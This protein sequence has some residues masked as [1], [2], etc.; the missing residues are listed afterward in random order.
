MREQGFSPQEVWR[1]GQADGLNWV[2]LVS[3]IRIVCGLTL[4]QAKEVMLRA[5]GVAESL[6]EYQERVIL[7]ALEQLARELE[8]EA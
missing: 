6:D 8:D 2:E 5:E 7:P 4:V 3:M 1:A